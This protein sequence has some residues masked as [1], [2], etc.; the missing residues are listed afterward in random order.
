MQFVRV[1]LMKLNLPASIYLRRLP[2]FVYLIFLLKIFSFFKLR[3][4]N[5]SLLKN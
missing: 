5:F 3:P 1:K 4:F 2:N